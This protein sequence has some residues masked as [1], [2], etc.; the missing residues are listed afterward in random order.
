MTMAATPVTFSDLG[1]GDE[2]IGVSC[3]LVD[4][5]EAVEAGDRIVELLIRGITF[6]VEAP[7]PG[8]LCR[9]EKTVA[10]IVSSGDVLGWIEPA[11]SD[12]KT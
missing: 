3:W 6:D 4:L 10:S 5:G 1:T 7:A 2:P 11:G 9:I 8:R 12:C